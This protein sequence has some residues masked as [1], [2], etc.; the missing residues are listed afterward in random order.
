[1]LN[2]LKLRLVTS[3][4]RQDSNIPQFHFHC[5]WVPHHSDTIGRFDANVTKKLNMF[6]PHGVDRDNLGKRE[7][8]IGWYGAN[9]NF[10]PSR[11]RPGTPPGRYSDDDQRNR[12]ESRDAALWFS[13]PEAIRPNPNFHFQ[14]R[15]RC[16]H[17]DELE[18]LMAA[19]RFPPLFPCTS[20]ICLRRL[21]AEATP[22]S[23]QLQ[24]GSGGQGGL[25]PLNNRGYS[26][27]GN[28]D[29]TKIYKNHTL[30]SAF[31]FSRTTNRND[32]G[33]QYMGAY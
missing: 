21:S 32:C 2:Q 3:T 30:N 25:I 12:R 27:A 14:T 10:V 4:R 19:T 15:L 17:S 11:M 33:S 18:R 20:L 24:P 6:Y 31:S 5:E 28:E 7:H 9:V 22:L 23:N 8:G 26:N 16:S 13:P 1:M 29:V